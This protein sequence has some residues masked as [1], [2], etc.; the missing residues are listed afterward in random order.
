MR[1][2]EEGPKQEDIEQKIDQDQEEEPEREEEPKPNFDAAIVFGHIERDLPEHQQKR[3][4]LQEG[5]EGKT[6][7]WRHLSDQARMRCAAAA[8]LYK[9]A[10]VREIIV[11]GG[12]HG[13]TKDNAAEDMKNYL[14]KKYNIPEE[15]IRT[16]DKSGNTIDN[17][18]Y[19]LNRMDETKDQNQNLAFVSSGYHLAR[20]KEIAKLFNLEGTSF[21]AEEMMD[22]REREHD[23]K[24]KETLRQKDIK[25]HRGTTRDPRIQ[26]K[27]KEPRK[28]T[29]YTYHGF[30]NKFLNPNNNESYRN[31]LLEE[32]QYTRGLKEMPEYW[33]PN[34][35]HV[36]GERLR[37]I[38]QENETLQK[39]LQEKFDTSVED[40]SD[41]DDEE[42]EELRKKL[43][44]VERK[45]PPKE[46]QEA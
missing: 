46:W 21:S 32:N 23:E 30:I 14:V 12:V 25:M 19:T 36:N 3:T 8:E 24:L 22:M 37:G 44:A 18:A 11:S 16:E 9:K 43:L 13:A 7:E 1:N 34:V 15:I 42:F 45:M 40:I 27:D 4:K 28:G 6:Q 41:M 38:I 17:L 20:I 10:N 35:A 5:E 33:I 29:G 31:M 39:F 2:L 26:K